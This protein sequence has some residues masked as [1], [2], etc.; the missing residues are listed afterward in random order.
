M[1]CGRINDQGAN[2]LSRIQRT[3]IENNELN[4]DMYVTVVVLIKGHNEMTY[5]VPNYTKEKK[6]TVKNPEEGA[7]E[8]ST[9][10][11]L[12]T[13]LYKSDFREQSLHRVETPGN[14]S[15]IDIDELVY[16][17]ILL[18]GQE[19]TCASVIERT[20]V[21][22]AELVNLE[23]YLDKKDTWFALKTL[24]LVKGG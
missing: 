12:P 18:I 10:S 3:G 23:N 5:F 14:A 20:I 6:P 4:D 9:L 1:H 7:A 15:T 19:K 8:L 13:S 21:T 17:K 24:L 2:D 16:Y 22:S 11:E